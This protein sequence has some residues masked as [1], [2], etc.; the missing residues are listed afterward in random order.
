MQTRDAVE[1]LH[2]CRE[3]SQL[4]GVFRWGYGN[5]EKSPLLLLE[6]ISQRWRKMLFFLLLDWN[7]FSWCTL[8][9]PTSQSKHASDNQNSCDVTAEFSYSHLK[10]AID[11]W[12]CVNYPNY[13]IIV[14]KNRK[15][16]L[17]IQI[18]QLIPPKSFQKRWKSSD[19]FLFSRSNRNDRKNPVPFANSYSTRFT[20][21]IFFRLSPCIR[22]GL[23]RFKLTNKNSA[24]G[25]NLCYPKLKCQKTL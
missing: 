6:N 19:V 3:F 21:A 17:E 8:I 13:F 2:N 22:R 10:T 9:F 15:F 25:K 23:L 24:S 12:E 11:Q 1:G 5:A 7:R 14:N 4:P 18:V 20:S 16:L